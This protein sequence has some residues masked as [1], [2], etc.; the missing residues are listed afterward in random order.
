MAK[1]G[2]KQTKNRKLELLSKLSSLKN[3]KKIITEK[4]SIKSPMI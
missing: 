3:G 4:L 2:R 1:F